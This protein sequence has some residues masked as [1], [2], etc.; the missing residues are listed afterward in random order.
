MCQG[1]D[2]DEIEEQLYK[3]YQEIYIEYLQ[4]KVLPSIELKNDAVLL[5]EINKRWEN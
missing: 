4:T 1:F 2:S 3:H 5:K